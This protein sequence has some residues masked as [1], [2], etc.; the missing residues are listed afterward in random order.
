MGLVVVLGL[1]RESLVSWVGS[2]MWDR[3]LKGWKHPCCHGTEPDGPSPPH[4][5]MGTFSKPQVTETCS[6]PCPT[7]HWLSFFLAL[8]ESGV[9]PRAGSGQRGKQLP[10]GADKSPQ[11]HRPLPGCKSAAAGTRAS[12]QERPHPSPGQLSPRAAHAG[13]PRRGRGCWVTPNRRQRPQPYRAP[14]SAPHAPRPGDPHLHGQHPIPVPQPRGNIFILSLELNK[15][16]GRTTVTFSSL[17]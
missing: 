16:K 17:L 5:G 14:S 2:S 1:P 7:M 15:H 12:Y 3:G 9:P 8:A 6:Q 4:A 10:P 13:F 11:P